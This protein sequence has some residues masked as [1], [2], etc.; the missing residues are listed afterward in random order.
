[1]LL[2]KCARGSCGILSCPPSFP[3]VLF[4]AHSPHRL[5]EC[6]HTFC[7]SCLHDWFETTLTQHKKAYPQYNTNQPIM[8]LL[9]DTLQR[10]DPGL[11]AA[12]LQRLVAMQPPRPQYTCPTCR[13]EVR[14]AP[15]ENFDLKSIVRT[16]AKASGEQSP[17]KTGSRENVDHIRQ[18]PWGSFF[19]LS[20][21][22]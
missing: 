6:G 14:T 1:M 22:P 3:Y 5:A 10:L 21:A 12:F 13:R 11:E 15:V 8:P 18:S 7:Q 9:R 2:V 16:V 17:K 20:V 19:P 4:R